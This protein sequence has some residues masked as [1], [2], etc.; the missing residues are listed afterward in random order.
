MVAEMLQ[1]LKFL[2]CFIITLYEVLFL[3]YISYL[4]YM[5]YY[6]FFMYLFAYHMLFNFAIIRLILNLCDNY[7][8]IIICTNCY[9]VKLIIKKIYLYFKDSNF[10]FYIKNFI[11]WFSHAIRLIKSGRR[12]VF[13]ILYYIIFL[14]RYD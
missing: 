3:L 13:K 6:M 9:N 4:C 5:F 12:F 10:S 11:I 8:I 7:F 14:I 1:K 2:L